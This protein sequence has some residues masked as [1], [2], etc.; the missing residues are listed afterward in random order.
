MKPQ[1]TE[2]SERKLYGYNLTLDIFYNINVLENVKDSIRTAR[3]ASYVTL[4]LVKR[5]RN[6]RTH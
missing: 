3:T 5:F 2:R 1:L 6:L 4:S